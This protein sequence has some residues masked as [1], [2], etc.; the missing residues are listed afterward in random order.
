MLFA[1]V[2]KQLELREALSAGIAGLREQ[3]ARFVRILVELRTWLVATAPRR[4]KLE[5][6][7]LAAARD[8]VDD[9]LAVDRHGQRPAHA[10]IIERRLAVVEIE[11]IGAVVI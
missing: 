9:R 7:P 8:I 1:R 10:G 3:A 5:G 11:V 2:E 6:R 4:G